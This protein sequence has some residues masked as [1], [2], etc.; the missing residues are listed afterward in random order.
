M[1]MI[2]LITDFG[3]SEY[4]GAMKGMIYSL[5]P[6]VKVVDI[7][8]NIEKFDIRHAAYVLHSVC[9]YFPHGTIHCVVVDPGVGT[10]RRSVIIKTND[11]FF[12]G[13]DNGVFSL[14]EGIEEIYEITAESKS[15]TFHGRDLFAPIAAKIA[16]GAEPQEFGNSIEDIEKIEL[17]E[18]EI[19]GDKIIGEVLCTDYFGN[20]ITNIK[21]EDFDRLGIAF[22]SNIVLEIDKKRFEP[23]FLE[24]YGFA[25]EGELCCLVGS[26]GYLEVAI[27]QGDASQTLGVYG[28]ERVVIRK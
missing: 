11:Y 13:P 2:T 15:K 17:K 20:A 26:G 12:I 1:V 5:C 22:K 27:N 18:V 7:S 14:V 16:C 6:D 21:S 3:G 19:T 4:V 8:H 25:E 28:G 24:S 10:E 23:R 9:G